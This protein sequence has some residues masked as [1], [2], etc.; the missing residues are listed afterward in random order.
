MELRRNCLICFG[1]LLLI[2][3]TI[4][5]SEFKAHSNYIVINRKA[6]TEK[7][8]YEPNSEQ[9][10]TP[11][12]NLN[13][14]SYEV[15]YETFDVPLDEEL[16]VYVISMARAYG[17]SPELVFAI[18]RKESMYRVD[19]VSPG[20]GNVGL[21]QINHS[22]FKWLSEELGVS[23][24]K[25][26]YNNIQAGCLILSILNERY[27]DVDKTLMAYNQGEG[28]AKTFWERGIFTT[29]YTRTIHRYMEELTVETEQEID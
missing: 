1:L 19:A 16:Q 29:H 20:G 18:I 25:D 4:S 6:S 15:D 23:D 14:Y 11:I 28:S 22:N 26:P 17:L 2:F 3:N 9:K 24:F 5:I 10:L 12:N 13:E 21:M 27:E 7:V 8:E